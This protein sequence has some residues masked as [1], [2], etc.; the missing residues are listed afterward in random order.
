MLSIYLCGWLVTAIAS[1]V[2]ANAW[3]ED[4]MPSPLTRALLAVLAGPL[5]PAVIVGIAQGVCIVWVA[6]RLSRFR[7]EADD[8]RRSE[9]EPVAVGG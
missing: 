1:V 8:N 5:W 3:A 4:S 7:R 9:A 2:L 6:R